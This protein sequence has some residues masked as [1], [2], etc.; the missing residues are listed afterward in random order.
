MS[1]DRSVR[2][3]DLPGCLQPRS[4]RRSLCA[5]HLPSAEERFWAKVDK[6]SP[7]GCW[8]WTAA[9]SDTG[10]GSFGVGPGHKANAHRYSYELVNGPVPKGL[11]LDHLCR[12]RRC[13]NPEHLEVVTPQ[14]N[15]LR[16]VG[17]AA[18]NASKAACPACGSEYR[19]VVSPSKTP[20]RECVPC[21][22][23][24]HNAYISKWRAAR[25]AG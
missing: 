15:N 10:Y 4:A 1:R 3:C 2:P 20:R 11:H 7:G 14:V 19:R 17:P 6:A 25:R 22:R 13:V 23:T 21:R 24:R 16:G 8:E 18:A 12:V 9:L 5:E